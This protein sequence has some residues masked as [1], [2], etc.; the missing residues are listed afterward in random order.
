MMNEM[1]DFER[2][3]TASDPQGYS[4]RRDELHKV[5]TG[6]T[7]K[8]DAKGHTKNA[9]EDLE[10]AFSAFINPMNLTDV[11][12]PVNASV[13]PAEKQ[14]FIHALLAKFDADSETLNLPSFALALDP[15]SP[16]CP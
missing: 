16:L 5:A 15:R 2:W 9:R 13:F 14:K 3:V 10:Q 6:Y 11:E 7:V 12:L 4:R 1:L 8:R